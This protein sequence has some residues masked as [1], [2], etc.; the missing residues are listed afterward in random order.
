MLTTIFVL[1]TLMKKIDF[2]KTWLVNGSI[3]QVAVGLT[4]H[5][6]LFQK[7]KTYSTQM[8]FEVGICQCMFHI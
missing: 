8:N 5:V 7:I 2:F 6:S 4:L 1:F 3:V